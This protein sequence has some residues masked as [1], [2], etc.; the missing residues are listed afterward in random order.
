MDISTIHDVD[1]HLDLLRHTILPRI[2]Q[3]LVV[4][5]SSYET[6]QSTLLDLLDSQREQI[7]I[8]RL[9]ANLRITREK[10]LADLESIAAINLEG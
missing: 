7:V 1:R 8:E 5:R 3:M 9:V 10:R 4:T 6:G 2:Q